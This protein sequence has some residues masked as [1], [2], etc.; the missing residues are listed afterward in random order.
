MI[1]YIGFETDGGVIMKIKDNAKV[2]YLVF[3]ELTLPCSDMRRA[4]KHRLIKRVSYKDYVTRYKDYD[5]KEWC[6]RMSNSCVIQVKCTVVD[7]QHINGYQS[8]VGDFCG[9]DW[10][11]DLLMGVT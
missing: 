3:D 1:N 7:S 11:V 10:T 5:G 9:Y 6:F 4:K 2:V 8:G